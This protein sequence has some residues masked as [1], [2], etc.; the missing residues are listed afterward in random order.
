MT[1]QPNIFNYATKELTQDAFII[2]LLHWA[3]PI[4]ENENKLLYSLGRSFLSSLLAKQNIT[5]TEIENL[6]IKP[7]FHKIDVFIS[8]IMQGKTYGII[9][10]DKVHSGDHSDQLLRYKTKIITLNSCDIIVGIYFKTGYQVNLTRVFENQYHHY[11]IKDFQRVLNQA[12]V[13]EI[14]NDILTQYHSYL[15]E[16]EKHFDEAH[17]AAENYIMLPLKE[18]NWWSCVK[19]F[20]TY[21][22]HFDAKWTSVANNR[23]PLLAFWFGGEK[24]MVQKNQEIA[25]ELT[26]Y[27]DIQFSRDKLIVAYR[28]GLNGN[29]Q[30]NSDIRNLVYD[31]FIPFLKQNNIENKKAKFTAAR[32][33]IKLTQITNLDYNINYQDFV[34]QLEKY[35][36]VIKMFV[37]D[38]NQKE[39]TL[40][41]QNVVTV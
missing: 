3:N 15:L 39:L 40:K 6:D 16:K 11:S 35:Q 13:K 14:N 29:T 8:F 2:W 41:A 31:A 28:L 20:H 5:L 9:I 19:F 27:L 21:K 38:Y 37:E 22:K 32:D 17:T 23:E 7:Q 4:Y 36:K 26:L 24:F 1:N 33:T 34:I 10:E 25:V 12:F 18:W 30:K